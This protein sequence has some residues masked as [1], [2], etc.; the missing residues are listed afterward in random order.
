MEFSFS[1]SCHFRKSLHNL[2][3]INMSD[4]NQPIKLS[5]NEG[6]KEESDYLRG[7]IAESLSTSTGS[8]SADD[9]PAYQIPRNLFAGRQGQAPA[10]IKEKKRKLF[11]M[12]AFACRGVCTPAQWIGIDRLSDQFAD[13]TLKLTTRQAFQLHGV[14]KETS[15]RQ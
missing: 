13:G 14:L 15:S 10:L 9:A 11:F 12:I 2:I 8:I 6:I 5:K 4:T 7:T 1:L 3:I